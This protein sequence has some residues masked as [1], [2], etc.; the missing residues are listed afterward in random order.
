MS[1]QKINPD[2]VMYLGRWVDK[3]TFR[4][5]VYGESGQKLANSYTEYEDLIASGIWYA[6]KPIVASRKRKLKDGADS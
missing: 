1:I 6:E 5:F 3:K 2:Q 4:A